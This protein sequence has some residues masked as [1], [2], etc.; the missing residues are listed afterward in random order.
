MLLDT[1][2]KDSMIFVNELENICNKSEPE[3]TGF[4]RLQK[5]FLAFCITAMIV[6]G[7]LCWERM[8]RAAFGKYG[9]RALGWMLH[10][11][12]IP[13]SRLWN[14]S[15]LR[16]VNICGI[17]GILV[18]DDTDRMRAKGTWN[19]FGIHKVKDKKTSG[20][21]VAQN[22][23][24]LLF[25][26]EKLTFPVGFSFFRPDPEWK[27][28]REKDK[29][30]RLNKVKKS[31]RPK[32]PDRNPD[33]PMKTTLA[34]ELITAFKKLVPT[35]EISAI[36]ADAAYMTKPFVSGCEAEFPDAQIISQIRKDWLVASNN[37]KT[38]H[39]KRVD[40]YFAGRTAINTQV[41]LRGMPNK[42]IT[43]V[44]ARLFVQ[45][46][47]RKLHI[48]ALKYDGETEYRYLAATKLS[49]RA[50]DIIRAYG[51]RW[52]VEVAIEDWKVYSGWGKMAFQQGVDGAC[53]GV[54]LSFVVDH[55]LSSHPLQLEQLKH[56]KPAWTAGSM[57]RF[58][59]ARAILTGVENILNAPNPK[60]MLRDLVDSITNVVSFRLSDK[61]MSGH[62]IG[63]FQAT[64]SLISKY[65]SREAA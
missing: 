44:S 4:S 29:E 2:D 46:Q 28:W 61:H 8:E 41:S 65:K 24:I 37:S 54:I 64:Q 5:E 51:I 42:K 27:T 16:M 43:M 38:K 6:L 12:S 7:S 17:K 23:V 47:Q 15:I 60:A 34:V 39:L 20:F 45:A 59:Q 22:L 63:E 33:Y 40:S 48:V 26:T 31:L 3:G 11:S 30:L 53:R 9:A 19:L 13:W 50:F 35:A 62:M 36:D 1:A 14:A 52:L 21:S 55:F 18:V 57:Q 49:W 25:V 32:K 56:G 10:H 58:I